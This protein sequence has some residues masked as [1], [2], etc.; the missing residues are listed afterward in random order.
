MLGQSV[1]YEEASEVFDEIIGVEICAPQIQRVC[2]YYGNAIDPLIKSNCESI[3]PHLQSKDDKDSVYVMVDGS[4]VNTRDDKW[5][6]LKLGRIFHKSQ[7]L[8]IQNNRREIM[9]SVYVSH[10][11]SVNEFFPKFER[12]LVGYGNKVII[13]DGAKWI[14]NWADDNYPGAIQILDFYHAKEK[15]VLFARHQ[16][17]KEEARLNWIKEQSQKLLD[18][19]LEDVISTLR[20]CRARNAEAKL[21]KQK[22]IDYYV[23]HDDRMQYKTYREKGL[24]IG[25]GPIEAAHRSVIQQRLKLSGQKWSISG[26]QAIANLRC[27]KHSGAWSMVKKI[28]AA[29]A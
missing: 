13:G 14:W 23:E 8:D 7:V 26:A 17:K 15:L 1:V 25:S 16:Y 12:H 4:M 29:A 28:I 19:R 22:A 18:N 2:T 21:A 27:Y 11:G 24:M 6:E 10:L 20:L 3:I 9:D 5:R